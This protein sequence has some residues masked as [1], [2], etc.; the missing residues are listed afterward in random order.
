ME[1]MNSNSRSFVIFLLVFNSVVSNSLNGLTVHSGSVK[2]DSS[3]S[4]NKTATNTH[5]ATTYKQLYADTV[6]DSL[7]NDTNAEIELPAEKDVPSRTSDE[8]SEIK[9]STNV[10]TPS[11]PP[12]K[13]FDGSVTVIF[14]AIFVVGFI[15]VVAFYIWKRSTDSTW[16]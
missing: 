11:Y 13:P 1:A 7:K 12:R 14:V 16:R 9:I 6:K 3:E 15:G 8:S 2:K 4:D 5:E 10:S